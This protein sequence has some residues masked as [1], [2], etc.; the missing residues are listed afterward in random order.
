MFSRVFTATAITLAVIS[1]TACTPSAEPTLPPIE[2]TSGSVVR[3]TAMRTDTPVPPTE[4]PSPTLVPTSVPTN[5][6]T[7]ILVLADTPTPTNTPTPIPTQNPTNTPTPTNTPLPTPTH[8][9]TPTPL[10]ERSTPSGLTELQLIKGRDHALTLIN[11]ARTAAGLTPVILG[12]NIAAQLHAESAL[13]N[14]FSS[15]WGIDGLKPYMRYTLGGGHQ[16]NAENVSGLDYCITARDGYAENRNVEYEIR[17]ATEGLLQSP[18][19]RRNILN[20]WHKKVN[21]GIALDDYNFKFVQH[22][23]GDYVDYSESPTIDGGILSF[24]GNTQNGAG[25]RDEDSLG[26]QIFYDPPVQPLTRGQVSRTY[27]LVF[28]TQVASMRPPL[29][30]NWYYDSEDFTPNH[31]QRSCPNPYEVPADAPPP[32]SA[33]EA[34]DFWQEAYDASQTEEEITITLPWITALDWIAANDQ[35]SVTADISDLLNQHGNGVYTIVVWAEIDGEDAPISEY[36]IFEP[37]LQPHQANV[38][39]H[40]MPTPLP[41]RAPMQTSTPDVAPTSVPTSTP[42]STAISTPILKTQSGIS[43][44]EIASARGYALARINQTRT[45]AGLTEVTLDGNTAAQS[46]AVD[47]RVNCFLSHWGSN[48]LKS[49]M[50]YSLAGGQHFSTSYITGSEY[51]PTDPERYRHRTVQEELTDLMDRL[52]VDPDYLDE[53]LDPN[54]RRV[55]FGVADQQPNFWFVQ[56]FITDF[57]THVELPTIVNHILSLNGRVNNGAS[58]SGDSFGISIDYDRTPQ[59]L[60]RG[61]LYHTSCGANGVRIAALREPLEIDRH[62][63]SHTFTLSGTRCQ[64]PYYVPVDAPVATSYDDGVP[65]I[66]NPY[67]NEAVWITATDWEVTADTFSVTANI[68]DLLSQHGNGVYTIIVWGSVEGQ[69][70]PIS[71]YSIFIPPYQPTE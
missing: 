14:C 44:D 12:D 67:D 13:E 58:L 69:D 49:Y 24:K 50:R 63:T 71:E 65:T 37:P 26:V 40:P 54:Y 34:H 4:Q 55:S 38:L 16:Y 35:F 57:I 23:E 20:R 41:T 68:A 42:T 52:L 9:P 45:A 27:C 64:D 22:F 70:A 21:I 18:G 56:R 60:T 48:G 33:D 30:P 7:P 59:A 1:L 36:S 6:P 43:E 3:L 17:D 53:V 32:K 11:Q 19:H 10:V 29:Q 5:S 66:R 2:P 39:A 46:H 47:M 8:T 28:G 31:S 61:Q 25:F 15:H 62:Y 51:C